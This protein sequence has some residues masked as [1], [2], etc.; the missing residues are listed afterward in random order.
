MWF[1]EIRAQE[2]VVGKFRTSW[3]SLGIRTLKEG[4][5]PT[6]ARKQDRKGTSS[7]REERWRWQC[8]RPAQLPEFFAEAAGSCE[9]MLIRNALRSEYENL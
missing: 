3:C 8:F 7:A 2:G 9:T 6:L 4:E 1:V 5:C